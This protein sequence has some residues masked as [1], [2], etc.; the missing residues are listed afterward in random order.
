[1]NWAT[2]WNGTSTAQAQGPV[3]IIQPKEM[4]PVKEPFKV[5][6]WRK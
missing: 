3:V 4:K 5:K 2:H 6:D 1:M